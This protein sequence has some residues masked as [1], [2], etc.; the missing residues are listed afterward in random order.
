MIGTA[1]HYGV[2]VSNMK[3]AL[4]FY[5]DTLGLEIVSEG[6]IEPDTED[7]RKFSNF[8]GVDNPE[9]KVVFLDAGGCQ[10]ELL[11]YRSPEG[12]NANEGVSNNDT[13]ASHFCLEVDD[14]DEIYEEL[15]ADIEFLYE[16]VTLSKG[17]RVAYM[18]D[19]DGNIVELSDRSRMDE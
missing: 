15:A 12:T 7:G 19:P 17:V 16:P 6:L 3:E 9:V 1:H 14:I 18:F 8:V 5:R 4:S 2:T 13:G 10:V 11:E